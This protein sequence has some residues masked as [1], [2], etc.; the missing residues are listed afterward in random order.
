MGFNKRVLPPLEIFKKNLKEN[1]S[2]LEHISKA[3]S[4]MGP[5]ETIAYLKQLWNNTPELTGGS[6]EIQEKSPFLQF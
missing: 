2:L 6:K 4:I 3:D 1:P 5:P